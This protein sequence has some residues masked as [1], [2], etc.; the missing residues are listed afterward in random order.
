MLCAM[1]EESGFSPSSLELSVVLSRTMVIV[2]GVSDL[3][4]LAPYNIQSSFRTSQSK[5]LS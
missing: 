1:S 2:L 4:S 3:L 5:C